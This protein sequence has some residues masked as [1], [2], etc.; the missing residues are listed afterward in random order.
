MGLGKDVYTPKRTTDNS[1][2][3]CYTAVEVSSY[4]KA[5]AVVSTLAG[6][7]RLGTRKGSACHVAH[8]RRAGPAT[9]T[10]PGRNALAATTWRGRSK[11]PHARGPKRGFPGPYARRAPQAACGQ[12]ASRASRR[13]ERPT[14]TEAAPV[15]GAGAPGAS[16]PSLA[17]LPVGDAARANANRAGCG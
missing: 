13:P 9:A 6:D 12:A 15:Y 11:R 14:N 2:S 17:A 5:H 10:M 1:H 4:W 3:G 16:S 8:W 7:R